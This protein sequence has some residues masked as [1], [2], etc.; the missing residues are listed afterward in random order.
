MNLPIRNQSQRDAGL[1]PFIPEPGSLWLVIVECRTNV[2]HVSP[3]GTGF[4]I[5]GQDPCWGLDHV[6]V[7]IRQIVLTDEENAACDILCPPYDPAEDEY[8]RQENLP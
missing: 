5:P 7:W 6:D 2:V 1:P 8:L 3:C 4:F